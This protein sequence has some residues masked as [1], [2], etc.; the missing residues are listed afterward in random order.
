MKFSEVLKHYGSVVNIAYAL[1]V[2]VPT[3][4]DWQKNGLPYP[5]QCQVEIETKGK[6]KA[7]V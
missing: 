1:Q 3:V 5:R 6:L 4:Y 7:K 2:S